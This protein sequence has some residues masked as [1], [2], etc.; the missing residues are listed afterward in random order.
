LQSLHD[1]AN[2]ILPYS[3]FQ[4]NNRILKRVNLR[5]KLFFDLNGASL[6]HAVPMRTG[7][8][9]LILFLFPRINFAN[10]FLN[11]LCPSS[12]FPQK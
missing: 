6:Q 8:I 2:I 11:C 9:D 10:A 12:L 4:E 3:A 5:K 1:A 7:K